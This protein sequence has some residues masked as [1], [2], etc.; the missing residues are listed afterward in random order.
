MAL[1]ELSDSE[2]YFGKTSGFEA[3][4]QK[5]FGFLCSHFVSFFDT[6]QDARPIA[7]D[8]DIWNCLEW[9]YSYVE[10]AGRRR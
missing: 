7:F 9:R 4:F 6:V 1:E 8:L 10:Y 3:R 2:S 5:Q